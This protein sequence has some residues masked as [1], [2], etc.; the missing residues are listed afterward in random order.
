[1]KRAL[2]YLFVGAC[3]FEHGQSTT[4]QP[5]ARVDSPAGCRTFSSQFD[6][7]GDSSVVD[8][9]IGTTATY[10]TAT[11]VM[12]NGANTL[13][14]PHLMVEGKAGPIDVLLVR[15]MRM[16]PNARLRVNGPRPLAIIAYGSVTL[17]TGAIIDAS[18]GGAGARM[19]CPNSAVAGIGNTGGAGGGGGGGF[20]AIGGS[21]GNGNSDGEAAPG[22]TGGEV[23]SMP[24]GPLGGCSGASG[25]NGD[26]P[27]GVGGKGGG[28]IYIA[29]QT[30]IDIGTSAGINVGGGGGQGGRR[31]SFSD[32][33]AG[34]GGGG[35][36]GMIML[37]SPIVH[38]VGVLAANGGGGGEASGGSG[39]GDNGDAGVLGTAAAAGGSGDSSSGTDGGAGGAKASPNGVSVTA[40]GAGGGGGGGGGV[41]FIVIESDDA[42]ISTTSP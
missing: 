35:S 22:G 23:V 4:T 8:V 42:M 6:T 36:G 32:G 12:V 9:V 3:S 30:R 31:E 5:D 10:D 15:D 37:E 24:A 21:G 17:E 39:G 18:D 2:L 7:C 1:V 19:T 11:G 26:D 28:A 33:D 20:A 25:G 13:N 16:A 40:G 29:A 38:S 27:G 34:G 14:V 41:G